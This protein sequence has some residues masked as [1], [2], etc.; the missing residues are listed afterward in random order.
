MALK[1]IIL[2]L[3]E[4]SWGEV[5][6]ILPVL[7]Q[8]KRLKPD[9]HLIIIFSEEWRR[10]NPVLMSRTL[11]NELVKVADDIVYLEKGSNSIPGVEQAEQVKIILKDENDVPFK[12]AI[13][14]TFP[15]A[16]IVTHQHGTTEIFGQKYNHPRNFNEW[17]K[18]SFKHDLALIC[19][20]IEAKYFYDI[21]ANAKFGVVGFPRYDKWWIKKLLESK[22]LKESMEAKTA[23]LYQRVFLFNSRWIT[24]E[25]PA[26]VIDY[27]TRSVAEIVLSDKR[28]FLLIKPH[29]RENISLL[30][31]YFNKYDS[32]R[33]MISNLHTTQLAYLSD[34][35]I[36]VWT[37]VT[38]DVLSVG[39][40]VVEFYRFIPPNSSYEVDKEGRF[41]S[42]SRLLG[43]VVPADNKD[44][45]ISHINNYFNPDADHTIW[46][47]Q[48]EAF[49]NL[50]PPNDNASYRA[51]RLI[52]S[53][54]DPSIDKEGLPFIQSAGTP[55]TGEKVIF[56]EKD[57][58]GNPILNFQLK[59]IKA[60]GMSISSILLR[61]LALIFGSESFIMTGTFCEHLAGETAK[62]FKEVHIAELAADLYQIPTMEEISPFNNVRIYHSA[63]I[64]KGILSNLKS[65]KIMFWLSTHETAGISTKSRTNIPIIEELRAIKESNVTDAIILINNM[66]YFQPIAIQEHEAQSVR[67][68]PSVQE[69]LNIIYRINPDYKFIVLGDIAIA[70]P[71]KYPVT[72]S[73]AVQACTLSRNFEENSS[74]ISKILEAETF[75]AYE[76]S[77][78]E[79]KAI[80]ALYMD[81]FSFEEPRIGGY[82]RFWRG[83]TFFGEKCYAEA[84]NEFLKAFEL[85][86]NHWRFLWYLAKSAQMSGD[87][88][89][90]KR[91]IQIVVQNAPHFEPAKKLIEQINNIP[92]LNH[93]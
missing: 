86:C 50:C 2:S 20:Q 64:L 84:K 46:K 49:R 70:Y 69:A 28:N 45:V 73:P 18:K 9:W 92:N 26:D 48:Q 53:L 56:L 82:Y 83:L 35:V 88:I 27:I 89:L 87:I 22:E 19:E 91:A 39:K 11:H 5:D 21:T 62:I 38:N 8:L 54:V 1:N 40:P 93:I 52:L 47:R 37:S 76:L 81:Y 78:N 59:R 25:A 34:F 13:Q 7:F 24:R 3:F 32:N 30:P 41:T 44:E 71:P 85:G 15:L 17:E 42:V 4:R 79:K 63:N 55:I 77:V 10:Y 68:Y 29:P 6:W 90:C 66:R 57:E 43:L 60:C 14:N 61:E 12:V 74:D 23:A 33:W 65:N 31:S 72:V 67:K 58:I 51:A 80:Q 75:I 36:S 16:K